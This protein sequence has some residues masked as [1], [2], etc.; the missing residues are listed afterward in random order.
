MI[1]TQIVL[2]AYGVLLAIFFPRFYPHHPWGLVALWLVGLGIAKLYSSMLFFG[3]YRRVFG[4]PVYVW[5][6]LLL[7]AVPAFCLWAG[8]GV[9]VFFLVMQ[10]Y[11]AFR[12]QLW[13][14]PAG[15]NPD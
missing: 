12:I 2:A 3:G 5:A 11:L 4:V 9:G 10:P 15:P 13:A 1:E 14:N 8:F 6:Y 7:S